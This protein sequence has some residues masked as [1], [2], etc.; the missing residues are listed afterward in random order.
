MT[1]ETRDDKVLVEYLQKGDK[2]AFDPTLTSQS[3]FGVFL[4]PFGMKKFLFC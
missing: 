2:K 4:L 1:F 3:F